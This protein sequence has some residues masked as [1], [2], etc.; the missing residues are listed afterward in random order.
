MQFT[1]FKFDRNLNEFTMYKAFKTQLT[2]FKRI[3]VNETYTW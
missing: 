3:K 1:Y 2:Y